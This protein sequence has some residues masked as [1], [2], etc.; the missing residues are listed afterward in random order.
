MH[1]IL[2]LIAV[3][4]ASVDT[5]QC[6]N[7]DRVIHASIGSTFPALFRS[8]AGVWVSQTQYETLIQNS[9]HLSAPCSKCYGAA[10]TCGWDNCKRACWSASESCDR[11]LFDHDCTTACNACTGF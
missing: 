3:A 8:F 9:V 2:L 7:A 11:C 4:A 1:L 5:H 6:T 10:Y